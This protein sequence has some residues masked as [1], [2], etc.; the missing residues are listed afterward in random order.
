MP[1]V[2]A[3]AVV[4]TRAVRPSVRV[5]SKP[6]SFRALA[7]AGALRVPTAAPVAPAVPPVSAPIH[8]RRTDQQ[9]LLGTLNAK[10]VLSDSRKEGQA[11]TLFWIKIMAACAAQLLLVH[12]AKKSAA[13]VTITVY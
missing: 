11:M 2:A 12:A 3:P 4:L 5:S 13:N 6:A 9:R 7:T 8:K 1:P 10:A